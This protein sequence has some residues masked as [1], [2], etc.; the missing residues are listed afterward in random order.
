MFEDYKKK[1]EELDNIEKCAK[2][3]Y[4]I[5]KEY[6]HSYNDDLEALTAKFNA[7]KEELKLKYDYYSKEELRGK[8]Y[9]QLYDAQKANRDAK[10][11]LVLDAI[12]YLLEHP[13][14]RNSEH[15]VW[16]FLYDEWNIGHEDYYYSFQ[17]MYELVKK[18]GLDEVNV[19]TPSE[20]IESSE[21]EISDTRYFRGDTD[22]CKVTFPKEIIENID[23]FINSIE[24]KLK[25]AD[26]E[27]KKNE[28]KQRQKRFEMYEQLK[29]EFGT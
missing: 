17:Q 19:Y 28:E 26:S 15:F 1:Q 12:Y 21:Y 23:E 14:Y 5:A 18:E 10:I 13:L 16:R 27:M 20:Y 11:L 8:A 2:K 29:A 6:L 22:E 3:E 7:D 25:E 9:E 4:E 24:A